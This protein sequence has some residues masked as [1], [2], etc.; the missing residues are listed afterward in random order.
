MNW[1]WRLQAYWPIDKSLM[2]FLHYGFDVLEVCWSLRMSQK[3]TLFW[4][5]YQKQY[6]KQKKNKTNNSYNSCDHC[7]NLKLTHE[8]SCHCIWV[9]VSNMFYFHFENLGSPH[10]DDHMFQKGWFNHQQGI[11]W[12]EIIMFEDHLWP[13]DHLI[14]ATAN[15]SWDANGWVD[16]FSRSWAMIKDCLRFVFLIFSWPNFA[17][18]E[19]T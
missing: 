3:F 7:S 14:E 19:V 6:V 10:F 2:I 1:H 15:S 18:I 4:P 13:S 16:T 8:I 9:V 5:I 11:V 17:K 12:I